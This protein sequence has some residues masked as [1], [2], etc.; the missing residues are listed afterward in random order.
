MAEPRLRASFPYVLWIICRHTPY[1]GVLIGF[2]M[3][4]K[5]YPSTIRCG[6]CYKETNELTKLRGYTTHFSDDKLFLH[7]NNYI[8]LCT[9]CLH[10]VL[11]RYH[12]YSTLNLSR[13]DFKPN[14][15][16]TIF[17]D[18][19]GNVTS[20]VVSLYSV[21]KNGEILAAYSGQL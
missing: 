9:E 10:S 15:G 19:L 5:I 13:K 14:V 2:R 18:S 11:K 8:Y 20:K 6:Y 21:G 16:A 4:T 3:I 7:D 1:I 17:M 12:S